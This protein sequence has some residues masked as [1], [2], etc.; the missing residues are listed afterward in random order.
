MKE[1]NYIKTMKILAY[2]GTCYRSDLIRYMTYEQGIR[3]YTTKIVNELENKGYVVCKQVKRDDK[4]SVD[5]T[6]DVVSLTRS[7]EIE[8]LNKL[9]KINKIEGEYLYN[10]INNFKKDFGKSEVE[11]LTLRLLDSRLKLLVKN[12]SVKIIPPEK[13]SLSYLYSMLSSSSPATSNEMYK[14]TLTKEECQNYLD[15][16]IVYTIG[17]YR[18]FLNSIDEELSD[19]TFMSRARGIYVST[20][21]LYVIYMTRKGNEKL[22]SIRSAGEENIVS[23]LESTLLRITNVRRPIKNMR[24]TERNVNG[25]SIDKYY[26]NNID[27]IVISG[28]SSLVSY[29]ANESSNGKTK[30]SKNKKK[31]VGRFWITSTTPMYNHVYVVPNTTEGVNALNYLCTTSMEDRQTEGEQLFESIN[32]FRKSSFDSFFPYD[33]IRDKEAVPSIYVPVYE[34]KTLKRLYELRGNVSIL[35]YPDM[36]EEIS[37]SVR[38]DDIHFYNAETMK[39]EDRDKVC[40]YDHNG[41]IGGMEVIEKTLHEQGYSIGYKK[42]QGLYTRSGK[43]KPEF[44]NQVYLGELSVW[45]VIN[46]LDL[47]KDTK[48]ISQ[49]TKKKEKNETKAVQVQIPVELMRIIKKAG[50]GKGQ[51]VTRYVTELVIG[52]TEKIKEDAQEY[53][54]YL[55]E[56][57]SE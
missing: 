29:M 18:E 41:N 54:T 38:K 32:S 8:L 3:Q 44:F 45:N 10:F 39:L 17:E 43:S 33:E 6:Y 48:L 34:V 37:K 56:Y 14:D 9:E 4:S 12:A 22:I 57:H 5:E 27:A 21:N 16:G 13:P 52:N 40:I 15:E 30:E 26:E 49:E 25:V 35:T 23:S 31:E 20:N 51:S 24:R 46:M 28:T 55:K 53:E 7:G 1:N 50:K 47:T 11:R 42:L 36:Y 2:V 19:R